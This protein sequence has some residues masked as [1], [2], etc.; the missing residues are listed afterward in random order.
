MRLLTLTT[1]I[2]QQDYLTGAIKGQLLSLSNDLNIADI[3]HHLPQQNF[4][5][6][7]YICSNAF[8]HFPADAIHVIILNSF[9][10]HARQ[11][12]IVKHGGQYIACPDNGIITMITGELPTEMIAL[13][14]DNT[15]NLL[16]TTKVLAEA[17]HQLN[18]GKTLQQIGNAPTKI[19]ERYPLRPMIS[20]NW[21]EGQI[22]FIDNF[23]N[24]VINITQKEFEEQ[25]NGRNFKI[26]YTRNETI[27]KISNSYTAVGESETL[28]WFNSAGYL[29]LAINKGNIAGLFGLESFNAKIHEQGTTPQNKWFYQTVRVFFE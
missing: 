11:W 8:K 10:M 6:A 27:D 25:R 28:A 24:V 18:N 16:Q 19:V 20:S 29:E 9:E 3:T 26:L 4:P 21:I 5:H 23:E 22:L 13:T 17:I 1:D 12:L 15:L 2:G 7:A 14:L